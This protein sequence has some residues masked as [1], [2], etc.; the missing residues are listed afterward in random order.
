MILEFNCTCGNTDPAKAKHY[1]GSLGYECIICL[2]CGIY[3]DHEGEH[4]PDEFSRQ[5]VLP[6]T[7]PIKVTDSNY[8]Q[9]LDSLLREK[10]IEA[11][12]FKENFMFGYCPTFVENGNDSVKFYRM[13]GRW[14]T[15]EEVR[16]HLRNVWRPV[17]QDEQDYFCNTIA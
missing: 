7:L 4:G 8:Q 2:N 15:W 3:R 12:L 17:R 5:Y 6:A 9:F 16:E 14:M 1:D 10:G 13:A 11:H